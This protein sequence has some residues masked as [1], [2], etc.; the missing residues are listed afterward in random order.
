MK[1]LV[2]H[3]RTLAE[4]IV[5]RRVLEGAREQLSLDERWY[6]FDRCRWAF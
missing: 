5:D 2:S 1:T 4:E 3:E 6:P